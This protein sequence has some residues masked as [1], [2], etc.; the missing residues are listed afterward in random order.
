MKIV[1]LTKKFELICFVTGKL[2]GSCELHCV[3]LRM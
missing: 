2:H 3:A 1:K